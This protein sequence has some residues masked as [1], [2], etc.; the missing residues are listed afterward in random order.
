MLISKWKNSGFSAL[1]QWDIKGV[2]F[3]LHVDK[4]IRDEILILFSRFIFWERCNSRL[5]IGSL[6]YEE[7][8]ACIKDKI[9]FVRNRYVF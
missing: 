7:L 3:K 9:N 2:F 1:P 4:G 5:T 8:P 6:I